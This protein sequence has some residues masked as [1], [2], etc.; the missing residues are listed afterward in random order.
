MKF[1]LGFWV[2]GLAVVR[3]PSSCLLFFFF[4]LLPMLPRRSLGLTAAVTGT[5]AAVEV[6]VRGFGGFGKYRVWGLG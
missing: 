3:V 4:R 5:A 6:K 1:N 2:T